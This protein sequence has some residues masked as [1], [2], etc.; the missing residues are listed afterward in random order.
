MVGKRNERENRDWKGMLGKVE[1]ERGGGRE[2]EAGGL[3]AEGRWLE[4][5]K[6]RES[7]GGLKEWIRRDSPGGG[8]KKEKGSS[9]IAFTLRHIIVF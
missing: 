9:S 8:E 3:E 4:E 1:G 2:A 6:G 7:G 5:W